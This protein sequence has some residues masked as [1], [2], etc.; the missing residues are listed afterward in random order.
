M[1]GQELKCLIVGN[2]SRRKKYI[3]NLNKTK[4]SKYYTLTVKHE[5]FL[6]FLIFENLIK[7]PTKG[8]GVQRAVHV[9]NSGDDM[10]RDTNH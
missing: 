3:A 6:T 5:F 2:S 1:D 8:G 9:Q 4:I 7:D 10:G